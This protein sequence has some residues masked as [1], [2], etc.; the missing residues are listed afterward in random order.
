M[1]N[2][3]ERKECAQNI[4]KKEIKDILQGKDTVTFIE[5]PRLRWCDHV[6][7]MPD[8]EM[9]KQMATAPIRNEEKRKTM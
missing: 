2:G 1:D 7:R 4:N 3:H 9:P 6:E 8:I 5:F